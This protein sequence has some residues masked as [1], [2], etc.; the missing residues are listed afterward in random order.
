MLI[1]SNAGLWIP[2]KRWQGSLMAAVATP[3]CLIL[4]DSRFWFFCAPGQGY[5]QLLDPI[6]TLPTGPATGLPIC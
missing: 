3:L 2:D 5:G 4:A 6:R 1:S